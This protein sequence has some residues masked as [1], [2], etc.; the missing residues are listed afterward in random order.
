MS[1][2]G[3]SGV[4]REAS[5]LRL[6][7]SLALVLVTGTGCPSFRGRG[8]LIDQAMH[9]D[10]I[11]SLAEDR[12]EPA[13]VLDACGEAGFDKCMEQCKKRQAERRSQGAR[14]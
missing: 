1:E 2:A 14:K 3:V 12:C 8:G 5:Y 9:R 4:E 6:V 7:A 10:L 13:D 11:E